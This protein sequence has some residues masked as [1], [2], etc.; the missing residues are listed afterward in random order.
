M[1]NLQLFLLILQV[2]IAVVM[3]ILVL[4]QKSDGDSLSG[5]G[6]G[7]GGLNSAMSS[8]ASANALTKITMILIGIFMLNCLILASLSN[9]SR[10][11]IEKELDQVIQQ[12]E[13]ENPTPQVPLENST[14]PPVK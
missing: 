5:I 9:S 7:S 14:I 12:Q 2:V 8:K 3:I 11:A 1:E 10:K 4:L 6:G 13:S